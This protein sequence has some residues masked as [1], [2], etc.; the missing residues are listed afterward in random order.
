MK[1]LADICAVGSFE[2]LAFCHIF[3]EHLLLLHL[4]IFSFSGKRCE[5]LML[6][7][8]PANLSAD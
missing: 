2:I 6:L 5:I 4:D 8:F 3:Y 1:K 7:H